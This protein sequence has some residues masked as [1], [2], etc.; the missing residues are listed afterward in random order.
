MFLKKKD[1]D[2]FAQP[3]K[4]PQNVIPGWGSVE[5]STSSSQ[6]QYLADSI[7]YNWIYPYGCNEQLS[8]KLI[9]A[10]SLQE[11]VDS[12]KDVRLPKK[13]E[14]SKFVTKSLKVLQERQRKTG[15]F[16]M[17]EAYSDSN[18]FLTCFI[19][20]AIAICKEQGHSIPG[21]LIGSW[22]TKLE[23]FL[24]QIAIENNIHNN[25]KPA[26]ISIQAFSLV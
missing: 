3:I 8:C 12:F 14:I 11:V 4:E 21:T 22:V 9:T 24:E 20:M 25:S 23:K 1:G 6:L 2:I 7:L 19:G 15:D 13:R 18:Y 17:W 26:S 16:G 10:V 5:L